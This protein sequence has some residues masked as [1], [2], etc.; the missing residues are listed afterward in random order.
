VVG[1]HASDLVAVTLAGVSRQ[2]PP[3]AAAAAFAISAVN[4]G[5]ALA[6]RASEVSR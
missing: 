1:I 4:L 2:I 5:L 3:R 6:A